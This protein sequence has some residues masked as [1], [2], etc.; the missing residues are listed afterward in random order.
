LELNVLREI[1]ELIRDGMPAD[2]LL[3][4]ILDK[5]MQVMAVH[6]GSVFLVDPQEA[7]GLRLVAAKPEVVL[8][9]PGGDHAPHRCSLVKSVI[10]SGK[11]LRIAGLEND[12]KYGS[13]YFISMPV[14]KS[15]Q[16][17]AVVNL[18]NKENSG[19][20]TE[21]DERIW[22]IMLGVIGTGIENISLRNKVK[23]QLA[24]I[25]ELTGMHKK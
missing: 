19:I 2:Q 22:S 6:N 25:K 5:A 8:E 11:T 3:T 14:Y 24:D 12:P 20:F 1:A 4:L 18:A 10:E 13:S 23:L 7:D 16:V 9:N 21:G 15:R 17:I